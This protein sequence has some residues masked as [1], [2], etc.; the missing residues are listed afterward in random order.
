MIFNRLDDREN[1][2]LSDLTP[3]ELAVL[4]PLVAGI[5]WLG[6][7]PAPVLRRTEPATR[8][9]LE[10][11]APRLGPTPAATL[12]ATAGTVEDRR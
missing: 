1:E 10:A 9:Y 5:V 8:H 6:L 3:R 7:Y 4:L 2:H 11:T 12:G